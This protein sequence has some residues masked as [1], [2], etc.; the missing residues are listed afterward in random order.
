MTT[1]VLERI[2]KL[3]EVI[4]HHRYN[5]H[6]LNKEEISEAALDSLKKELFDLE[7]QFQN[8]LLLILRHNELPVV[9]CQDLKR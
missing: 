2:K 6:V 1:T 8:I 7:T 4:E 5:V 3:R 9:Y